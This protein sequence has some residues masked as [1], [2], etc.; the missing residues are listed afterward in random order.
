MTGNKKIFIII[1]AVLAILALWFFIR[2]VVGGPE[3]TWLS[4][5]LYYFRSPA[6]PFPARG[7]FPALI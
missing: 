6:S 7:N 1:V 3:D 4:V 5:K 2:F